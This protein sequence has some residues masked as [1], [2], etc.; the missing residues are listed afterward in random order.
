MNEKF[1]EFRKNNKKFTFDAF[2][3]NLKDDCL[4]LNYH[5][6]FDEKMDFN[7]ILRVT[8]INKNNKIVD[9][10][11]YQKLLICLGIVEGINYYK[12]MSPEIYK[13]D[14]MKL[15][16]EEKNWWSKLFYHGLGE[17]RYLNNIEISEDEFVKFES[18]DIEIDK[19]NVEKLEGNL[20]LVG[21]GKDSITSLEI[22]SDEKE[23]NKVLIVNARPSSE[24]SAKMAGYTDEDIIYVERIIDPKVLELN[25]EG[26]LNGHIPF[27]AM[28][29]FLSTTIS[30]ILGIKNIVVS[31]ENSANEETAKGA[32]HQYSKSFEFENDF[33]NY[34]DKYIF[35][36]EKTN[37]YS[38][39][40]P[41]LE[42][43]IVKIF[44][45]Y[46]KYFNI[47]KSCNIGSKILDKKEEWCGHCPKCLFVYIMLRSI[48]SEE[49]TNKI[50][51]RNMLDDEKMRE[52]FDKLIGILPDKPFECIGTKDEVNTALSIIIKNEPNNKAYLIEYYRNECSKLHKNDTEIDKILKSW[53]DLNNVPRETIYKMIQLLDIK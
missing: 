50:I 5:Y 36:N 52:D 32:N 24:E 16:D 25:K 4:E 43:Q 42:I 14:L 31:N 45:K 39:M 49:E 48:L 40:R 51:G 23:H 19:V 22:L 41:L 38:L 17:Y 9:I 8:N 21:G 44:S 28:L 26:Y 27:S 18:S 53:D 20:I 34:V 29:A 3:A 10:N 1:T 11:N 15:S 7:H 2:K 47:F 46:S 30:S 35:S 33:R 13:V 12:L 37:Y 6:V